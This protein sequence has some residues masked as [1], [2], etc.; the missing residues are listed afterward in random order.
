MHQGFTFETIRF[1]RDVM[2][3]SASISGCNSPAA[4]LMFGVSRPRVTFHDYVFIAYF[5]SH[6]V[7]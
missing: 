4:I 3:F 6:S 2:E 1:V 5:C 7:C